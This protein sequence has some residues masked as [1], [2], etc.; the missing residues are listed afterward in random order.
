MAT[1]F[2]W[3]GRFIC[4]NFWRATFNHNYTQRMRYW[5][6]PEELHQAIWQDWNNT[7]IGITHK[8]VQ[9]K[10]HEHLQL[11]VKWIYQENPILDAHFLPFKAVLL[12]IRLQRL[13]NHYNNG[14]IE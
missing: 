13:V 6:C 7:I 8:E 5:L 9:Q 3:S 14:F 1:Y 10:E 11:A 4:S 2:H 12:E